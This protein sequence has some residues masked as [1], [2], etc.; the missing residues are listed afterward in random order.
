MFDSGSCQ[1]HPANRGE[2]PA[3]LATNVDLSGQTAFDCEVSVENPQGHAVDFIVEISSVT[4]G[5]E[6]ASGT[7]TVAAGVKQRWNV[8]LGTTA[9]GAHRIVLRTVMSANSPSNHQA[10]A[11]WHAPAFRG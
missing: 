11:N 7:T 9:Y 10:F 1:L 5:L 4:T 8:P 3:E 6:I 2:A